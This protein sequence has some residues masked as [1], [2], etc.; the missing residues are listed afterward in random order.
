[1][2]NSWY[3]EVSAD[4]KITQGELI[5]DCPVLEWTGTVNTGSTNELKGLSEAILAD[6]VVMTQACDLAQGKVDN[7]IVCPHYSLTQF[8]D[9]AMLQAAAMFGLKSTLPRILPIPVQGTIQSMAG[10]VLKVLETAVDSKHA[11]SKPQ[12]RQ[13]HCLHTIPVHVG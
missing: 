1:M 11:S 12:H 3:T 5:F 4:T 8:T 13:G 10:L 2:T 6:I 7:V 9:S